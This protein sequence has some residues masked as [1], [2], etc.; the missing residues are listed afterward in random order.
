L[1]LGRDQK[2]PYG[3]LV[4]LE[5]RVFAGRAFR[6]QNGV[7]QEDEDYENNWVLLAF[8]KRRQ[9]MLPVKT[10]ACV[11]GDMDLVRPLGLAGI[12]CAV[13]DRPGR[14]PHFSR[15][16]RTGLDW[17]GTWEQVE[18]LVEMLV[19][20]GATQSEPPVL[21]YEHDEYL[22][23]VSRYRERLRQ[24]FRFVIAEPTLVEDLVDKARFQ[25]LAERLGLPVPPT[26][27]L[28]PAEGSTHADLDLRFPLII[29]PLRRRDR[30][31]P[32]VPIG[33]SAKAL[34]IDTPAALRDLWPRLAAA[35]M[36]VLAQELIPGPETCIESYHVYVDEQGEIV[37]EFTGQKI[38]TYPVECGHSTALVIT[39]T[40]DVQAIG[41]ELVQ[42]LNLRG[43]AKFDFKRGP[44]GKLYLLE[45]NPRFNLWHH[46]GAIAG[47]NLPA[48]VY[49]D[50]VGL[51]RPV[52]PCARPG[53]RWC[54]LWE[55]VR[56]AKA[57]G[58]PL[59]KWLPWVLSCEVKS[60]VAWDDPMP[61]LRGKLWRKFSRLAWAHVPRKD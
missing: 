57:W 36:D 2:Q 51:P 10:L 1:G 45:V 42:R 60:E 13:V 35:P 53:V 3:A 14:P 28:R 5:R 55:D 16:T 23:L 22:L 49:C 47:V 24:S 43:V 61:F 21:F 37:G 31:E 44:D 40:A 59:V 26:R 15:F 8:A 58:V 7:R 27:R 39:D 34:R 30:D 29:K 20:F 12:C 6:L 33:G 48:L 19:R 25:V 41:R 50:L 46:P 56:A 38:R 54:V 32:W 17:T 4:V 52:I 18:E 11:M 9:V